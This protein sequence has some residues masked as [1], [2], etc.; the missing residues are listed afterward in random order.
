MV[1]EFADRTYKA[2]TK[3]ERIARKKKE[4]AEK[5]E[6]TQKHNNQ[7]KSHTRVGSQMGNASNAGQTQDIKE[8]I[9]N[10]GG[11]KVQKSSE[12]VRSIILN[13]GPE[14]AKDREA[15]AKIDIANKTKNGNIFK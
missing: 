3:E 1:V 5:A 10:P 13:P 12:E 4:D 14:T 9:L 2:E 7:Y 8:T 6:R 11:T 15:K